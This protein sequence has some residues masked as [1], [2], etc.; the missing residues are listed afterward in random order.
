MNYHQTTEPNGPICEKC[1]HKRFPNETIQEK[2]GDA[3]VKPCCSGHG[4]I[5]NHRDTCKW[6]VSTTSAS[7]FKSF[8]RSLEQFFLKILVNTN[9]RI[10]VVENYI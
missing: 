2:L 9:Q 4:Y 1:H 10:K 7:N 8:S 5:F 3:N 6:P